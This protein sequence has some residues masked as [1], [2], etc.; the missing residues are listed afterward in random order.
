MLDKVET[1]MDKERTE[2]QKPELI[3]YAGLRES[4]RGAIS[5]VGGM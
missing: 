5:G 2:Y 1:K 4:T 3:I